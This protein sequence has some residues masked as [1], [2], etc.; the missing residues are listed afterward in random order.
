MQN[1]FNPEPVE[2]YT[3]IDNCLQKREKDD[4]IK[5]ILPHY[6]FTKTA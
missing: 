1:Y 3:I 2:K 6:Y 5:V 4:L